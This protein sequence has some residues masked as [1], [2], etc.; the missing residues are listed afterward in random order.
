[1]NFF[2]HCA[3][4]TWVG[5]DHPAAHGFGSMV[6]DFA[7]MVRARLDSPATEDAVVAQGID[8]H[9]RTDSA[10][11]HMPA[12][13]GLM[14]EL[15]ARLA[16]YGCARGPARAVA[17]IGVELLLDGELATETAYAQ[18]Y[19]AAIGTEASV[20]RWDPADDVDGSAAM[21]Q[22]QARLVSYGV[23]HDLQRT[24]AIVHRL[25]RMLQPRPRLAPS[26]D[27]LV[28]IHRAIDEM[29]QRC[30]V[31][32]PTVIRGLRAALAV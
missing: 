20:L 5:S 29:R 9:H 10:F 13:L 32:T 1:M 14:R 19:L 18:A 11:H 22:L 15:S 3:V 6:P 12:V 2:G 21:A 23:P 28:A 7:V 30:A 31:A 27:D 8:L 16:S 4:A 25:H 26:A 24:D 17:H